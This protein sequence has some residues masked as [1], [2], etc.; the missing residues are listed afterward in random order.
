[1]A[2]ASVQK[3]CV[4]RK[5]YKTRCKPVAD[6]HWLMVLESVEQEQVC[7]RQ[8]TV[9]KQRQTSLVSRQFSAV[10]YVH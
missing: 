8:L 7:W 3:K 10:V 1:M 9:Q 4:V 2:T 6:E 5:G